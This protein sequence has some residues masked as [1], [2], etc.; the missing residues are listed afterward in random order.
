M[1]Y[2]ITRNKGTL[3]PTLGLPS[4]SIGSSVSLQGYFYGTGIWVFP[5]NYVPANW[6]EAGISMGHAWIN[7]NYNF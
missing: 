7:G 4:D 5:D 1:K 3:T 2:L 6:N